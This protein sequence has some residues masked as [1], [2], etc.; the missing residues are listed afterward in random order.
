[1]I[2]TFVPVLKSFCNQ[3]R[4]RIWN[5][6][7]KLNFNAIELTWKVQNMNKKKRGEFVTWV[8]SVDFFLLKLI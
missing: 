6:P 8:E 5:D 1:M 2:G 7:V 4:R 3:E